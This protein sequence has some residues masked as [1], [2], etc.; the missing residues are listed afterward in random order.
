MKPSH[1]QPGP[2]MLDVAAYEVTAEEREILQHP[3]VGGVILFGRNYAEPEQLRALTAAIRALRPDVLISVDH[4][5]GRVQRFRDGFTR[6]PAMRRLGEAW[7]ADPAAA[8]ARCPP[9]RLRAGGRAARPWR[10]SELR[11]GAGSRLR[12]QFGDR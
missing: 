12:R 4:E 10:R 11:A 6:L 1:A 3:L 9:G 2:V 8:K 7:E 5:G